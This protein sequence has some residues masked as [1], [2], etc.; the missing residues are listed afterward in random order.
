MKNARMLLEK[1]AIYAC[2]VCERPH[3]GRQIFLCTG[4]GYWLFFPLEMMVCL[5]RQ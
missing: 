1:V 4:N 3:A 2:D 5:W